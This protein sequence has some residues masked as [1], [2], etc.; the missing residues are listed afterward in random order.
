MRWF[1]DIPGNNNQ[2]TAVFPLDGE[3]TTISHGAPAT[4]PPD[5]IDKGVKERII[6]PA[7][8]NIYWQDDAHAEKA[9]KVMNKTN[10][11]KVGLV[12]LGNTSAALSENIRK[13]IPKAEVVNATDLVDEV[14]MVKSE[15]E[16]RLMRQ[17]AQMHEMTWETAKSAIRPGRPAY[18]AVRELQIAQLVAGS[19]EQQIGITFGPFG[20]STYGQGARGNFSK[21][22]FKKGDIIS[23][24]LVESSAPGGYWYDMRRMMSIGPVPKEMQ[25]AYDIVKEARRIMAENLKAGLKP[26]VALD[27]NDAY[28][29]SKGLP[30][31]PRVGGHGQGYALVERP[32]IHRDEP[33]KLENNMIVIAHPTAFTKKI[34]ASIADNLVVTSSGAVPIYKELFDDDEIAVVG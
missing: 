34:N 10:P 3:I 18:E 19:E 28:M 14:R 2:I 29:K 9:A 15:E 30:P 20:A 24:I 7:F 11:K 26:G 5:P 6:V 8:P 22:P 13:H 4:L 1:T 27:A 12:G 16:L 32:L 21:R 33:A 31:E 17:A 25:E 23:M